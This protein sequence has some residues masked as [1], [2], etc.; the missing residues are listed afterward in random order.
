MLLGNG[1]SK[2]IQSDRGKEF[3]GKVT[4]FHARN[5]KKICQYYVIN[6]KFSMKRFISK[7]ITKC[8]PCFDAS[9]K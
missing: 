7:A 4:Y 1:Y 3:K 9:K 5:S 8:C 6:V 2:K